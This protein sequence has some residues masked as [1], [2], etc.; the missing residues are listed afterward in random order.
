MSFSQQE[1]FRKNHLK[2]LSGIETY[3]KVDDVILNTCKNHL[4]SLSGIETFSF[5]TCAKMAE[6]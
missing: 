3:S 4:K 1:N 6:G 2:S 5:S